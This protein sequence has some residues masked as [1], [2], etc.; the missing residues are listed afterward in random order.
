MLTLSNNYHELSDDEEYDNKW[1]IREIYDCIFIILYVLLYIISTG[2]V[3]LSFFEIIS[4]I[5]ADVNITFIYIY[6]SIHGFINLLGLITTII[7]ICLV[8]NK[9]GYIIVFNITP[10]ISYIVYYFTSVY[11]FGADYYSNNILNAT[12]MACCIYI[13]IV[14]ILTSILFILKKCY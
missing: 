2:L 8:R 4:N 1:T 9:Y 10:K 14:I 6:F 5:N 7:L 11:I 13:F 12:L 3:A